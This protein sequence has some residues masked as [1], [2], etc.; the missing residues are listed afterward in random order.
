MKFSEI[1]REYFSSVSITAW[2]AQRFFL[3]FISHTVTPSHHR[4]TASIIS[5]TPLTF[6][7]GYTPLLLTPSPAPTSAAAPTTSTYTGTPLTSS[8]AYTPSLHHQPTHR[9]LIISLQPIH[10]VTSQHIIFTAS[11]ASVPSYPHAAEQDTYHSH[12]FKFN[13]S[14]VTYLFPP[15]FTF[16]PWLF[17]H[18]RV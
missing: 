1:V 8:P 17:L 11:L 15:S 12:T 10:F 13:F 9:H 2:V 3:T 4:L 18:V 5:H 14:F 6:W 7:L 16:V